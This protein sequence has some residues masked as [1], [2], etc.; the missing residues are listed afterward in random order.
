MW[1]TVRSNNVKMNELTTR[2]GVTIRFGPAYSPWSNGISEWNHA[3]CDFIIMKL[4]EE[5]KAVFIESFVK[6]VLGF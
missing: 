2:L 3:S 1:I 6:A 4:M 5:K